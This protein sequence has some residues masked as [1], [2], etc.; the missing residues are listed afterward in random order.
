MEKES[1]LKKYKTLFIG[2]GIT[3][4]VVIAAVIGFVLANESDSNKTVT[5]GNKGMVV[6]KEEMVANKI[7]KKDSFI[8]L[9]CS[10]S[11]SLCNDLYKKIEKSTIADDYQVIFMDLYPYMQNIKA[12]KD[13]DQRKEYVDE[14]N[15][16]KSKYNIKQLPAIQT[17]KEGILDKNKKDIF[18]DEYLKKNQEQ[19]ASELQDII[20]D[21]KKWLSK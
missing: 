9:T 11:N 2:L 1:L 18:S 21:I 16:L 12:A 14:F 3:S 20:N 5:T 19:Q 13:G 6:L 17:Y 4:L 8:L 7:N 10:S 15:K